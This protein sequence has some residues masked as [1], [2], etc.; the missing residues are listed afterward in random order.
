LRRKLEKSDA[1]L[2]LGSLIKH[3]ALSEVTVEGYP[4]A[5]LVRTEDLPNIETIMAGGIPEVWTPLKETTEDEA[6]F[7]SPLDVVSARGRAKPLFDF[8]YIWE[9]YKPAHLRR[10][11]YYTMPILYGDQLVGRI[12]P[13]L[14]RKTETLSINGL[15]L[16]DESIGKS[17]A[18]G[19]ALGRGIKRLATFANA[20]SIDLAG[21]SDASLRKAAGG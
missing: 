17:K 3:G 19:V 11:G 12:E 16:D 7:L 5:Q 13:Q 8:D 21:I 10:W 15:W 14:D 9:V 20:K 2:F 4:G 6:V 18:F 1:S